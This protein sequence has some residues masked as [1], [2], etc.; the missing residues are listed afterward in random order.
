MGVTLRYGVD[1]AVELP[2]DAARLA[3]HC[4]APRT[5]RL[6][7]VPAAVCQVLASPLDF[8]ALERIAVPGDRV[9][10]AIDQGVPRLP[11][12]VAPV[13]ATLLRVGVQPAD[14]LLL[15]AAEDRPGDDPLSQVDAAARDL[16]QQEVHDPAQRD[17]N[18]YL[19]TTKH[20]QRVYLNRQ[21]TDAD[22]VLPIGILRHD[23]L[24]GYAGT[25]STLYPLFADT[26][27]KQRY[28]RGAV[29]QNV[30]G[31]RGEVDEV[32][33]LLGVQFSIQ[34][35]PGGGDTVLDVLAGESAAVFEEGKRRVDE[36]YAY[37]L[38]A[39][40]GLVIATVTGSQPSWDEI[41]RALSM[42]TDAVSDG[43]AIAICSD[44]DATGA[45][46][47]TGMQWLASGENPA[48]VF[49]RVQKQ[50]P[51]D[52]WPV[53]QLARGLEKARVYLLSRL[54]SQRVEDLGLV[55]VT[56]HAEL[57]RLASRSENCAVLENANFLRLSIG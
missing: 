47:G 57:A 48:T 33:W 6:E 38:P 24:L 8:P 2:L 50:L 44:L 34:V 53:M 12:L 1:A 20:N 25:N 39:P 5:P 26:E 27:T 22:L 51:E 32:G 10:L 49:R 55:P 17:H 43:G 28:L 11:Q 7:D 54:D 13:V 42:A 4:A 14:I 36:A 37:E 19:A 29:D 3:A 46:L 35:I 18:A 31:W 30:S 16:I 23:P 45:P 40:A 41:A 15:R 9:V 56:D 21:L 52:A